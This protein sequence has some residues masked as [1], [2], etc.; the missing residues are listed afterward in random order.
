MSSMDIDSPEEKETSQE[1]PSAV[2]N[3]PTNFPSEME[4]TKPDTSTVDVA[5]VSNLTGIFGILTNT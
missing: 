3:E 2:S 4:A 1:M 5:T